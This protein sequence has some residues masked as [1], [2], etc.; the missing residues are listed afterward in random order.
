MAID[1]ADWHWESAAELYREK[2]GTT[3]YIPLFRELNNFQSVYIMLEPYYFD[4]MNR[5]L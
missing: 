2:H 1:K 3:G 5:M 4:N